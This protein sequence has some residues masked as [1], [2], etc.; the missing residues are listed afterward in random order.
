L[1]PQQAALFETLL[2]RLAID[3]AA[4][5]PGPASLFP[6]LVDAV[7]VRTVC[8]RRRRRVVGVIA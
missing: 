1:R 2:P 7:R 8:Y 4:P 6:D 3:L 5:P